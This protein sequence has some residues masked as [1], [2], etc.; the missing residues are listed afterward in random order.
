MKLHHGTTADAARKILAEGFSTSAGGENW[1]VS[2][3]AVYF[4]SGDKLAEN[5]ESDESYCHDDAARRACEQ[6]H[7]ALG[8]AADCRAVVFEVEIDE[9][10]LQDDDSCPNMDG[11]VCTFDDVP[12]SSITGAYI[13]DDLTLLKGYFLAYHINRDLSARELSPIEEKIAKAMQKAEICPE[14][15][16]EVSNFRKVSLA[17][18]KELLGIA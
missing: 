2:G 11:A 13:T 5:G 17:E 16:D 14:D 3:E 18:L 9:L 10:E 4:W 12:V 1:N 15:V 6:A 7:V 8:F